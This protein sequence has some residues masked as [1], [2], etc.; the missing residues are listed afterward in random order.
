[1]SAP[2]SGE[3]LLFDVTPTGW[4]AKIL[5]HLLTRAEPGTIAHI[6]GGEKLAA[7]AIHSRPQGNSKA[8]AYYGESI[9]ASLYLSG[10]VEFE[11]QRRYDYEEWAGP[12]PDARAILNAHLDGLR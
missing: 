7:S 4:C 11:V 3:D 10:G 12:Q 8:M 1:M 6:A 5:V 2:S 9:P